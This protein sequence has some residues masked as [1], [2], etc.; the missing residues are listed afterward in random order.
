MYRSLY[1]NTG[2]PIFALGTI[3]KSEGLRTYLRHIAKMYISYKLYV[4]NKS[5]AY[6]IVF[7]GLTLCIY[8]LCYESF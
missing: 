7:T 1:A 6:T 2:Q 5:K 4:T 8:Y 3:A